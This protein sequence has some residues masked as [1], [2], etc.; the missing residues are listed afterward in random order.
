MTYTIYSPQYIHTHF[1]N[2]IWNIYTLNVLST[3]INPLFNNKPAEARNP[4]YYQF[5][6]PVS[7]IRLALFAIAVA[8]GSSFTGR[9]PLRTTLYIQIQYTVY[10]CLNYDTYN[11]HITYTYIYVQVQVYTVCQC[12]CLNYD[13]VYIHHSEKNA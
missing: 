8:S 5:S 9:P 11:V 12:V 6:V 2:T 1:N 7:P 13:I 10:I 3:T 4:N